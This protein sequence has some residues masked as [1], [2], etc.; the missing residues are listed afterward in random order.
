MA[1]PS[2]DAIDYLKA[3]RGE[4]FAAL[5]RLDKAIQDIETAFATKPAFANS[6]AWQQMHG[7]LQTRVR[8]VSTELEQ[9]EALLRDELDKAQAE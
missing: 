3:M 8:T 9:I 1:A 2:N 7:S 6:P 5:D 4:C